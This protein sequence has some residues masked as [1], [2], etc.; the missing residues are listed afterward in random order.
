[1]HIHTHIA[2][3]CRRPYLVRLVDAPEEGLPRVHLHEDAAE[4][5]H[6][7]GHRVGQAQHHLVGVG[8]VVVLVGG[9]AVDVDV[10][11][12]ERGGVVV[13]GWMWIYIYILI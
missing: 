2:S 3:P 7:D 10:Y 8:G 1:M 9:S 11:Y 12:N 5:P 6:V 4:G 13:G